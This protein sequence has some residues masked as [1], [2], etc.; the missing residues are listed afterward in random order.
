MASSMA[1]F[2]SD[3]MEGQGK[4]NKQMKRGWQ[5]GLSSPTERLSSLLSSSNFSDLTIKF[6]SKKLSIKV[7]RLVLAMTS[8]VFEEMLLSSS[9]VCEFQELVLPDDPPEGF[10]WLLRYMYCGHTD[11]PCE[12]IALQVSHLANKYK[13]EAPYA[14]CSK[15]LLRNLNRGNL[16][17]FY[18]AAV[19]L[20]NH[21]LL[22]I[23]LQMLRMC[24]CEVLS[25]QQVCRM[26]LEALKHLLTQRLFLPS[27]VVIFRAAVTWGN[28]QLSTH[29]MVNTPANLRQ[30]VAELLP[31]VRFLTMSCDEFVRHVLPSGVLTQEECTNILMNIEPSENAPSLPSVCS[32]IR[33]KRERFDSSDIKCTQLP[34]VLNPGKSCKVQMNEEQTLISN[35]K[36]SKTI[37][38]QKVWCECQRFDFTATVVDAA[39]EMLEFVQSSK[40]SKEFERPV[41]LG[42]SMACKITVNAAGLWY[43]E[44]HP[45]KVQQDDVLLEGE[46]VH[47]YGKSP[48]IYYWFSDDY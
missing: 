46:H 28:A 41:T 39:G 22:R 40:K 36:T 33:Q 3:V 48:K 43:S 45:F 19:L 37:H 47:V 21:D 13:I 16:L 32:T 30:E 20:H 17:E 27:E 35:L 44:L 15:F 12:M 23:C 34:T 38:I 26:S 14:I 31:L 2:F 10:M 24:H 7:H 11:L 5:N 25:S 18:N 42:P 1:T 29:G 8:E 6:L 4:K 9:S